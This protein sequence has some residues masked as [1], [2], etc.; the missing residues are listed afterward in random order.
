MN[1]VEKALQ[2]AIKAHT[3]QVDKAGQPYINHPVYLALQMRDA[4]EQATALLHDVLEDSNMFTFEDIET[5]CGSDVADA[6][7]CLTHKEH[8]NYFDYIK[9]VK[10]NSVST[11]VKIADLHHNMDLSRI[12]NPTEKDKQRVLK[13][14]KAYA[15]LMGDIMTYESI[16]LKFDNKNRC[17]CCGKELDD[18]SHKV[19]DK[20]AS[21]FKF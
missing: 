17:V 18:D 1:R 7:L 20:C 9:R 2:M 12:S 10:T 19:C 5:A 16:D 13:Y 14:E 4:T 8:E 21:E 6:V 11:F 3:G 15:Y